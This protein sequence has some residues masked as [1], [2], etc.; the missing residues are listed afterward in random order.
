MRRFIDNCC[1]PK[2]DHFASLY[3]SST[4]LAASESYWILLIQCETFNIEIESLTESRPLTKSSRLFSLHP[5]I[6]QSG[7]L[8]LG[9]RG[10]N[11]Q[12]SFSVKHP[13]ILPG[14]DPLTSVIITS[15]HDRLMHAGPTI[16]T[17]LLSRY[18][19][20]S[21]RKIV[22]SITHKCAICRHSTIRPMPQLQGQLF[23][24]CIHST[25]FSNELD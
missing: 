20:M 24:E 7:L 8:R 5:F 15:E 25:S 2:T 14:K 12:M 23:A 22:R 17:A 21:C 16:L 18:H 4:E 10:Q 9:G 1:K 3:L 11:A 19:I 13:I 6:D